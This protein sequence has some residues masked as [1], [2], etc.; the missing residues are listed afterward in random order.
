MSR[1]Q[2]GSRLGFI[3]ASA[4]ATVGL[5]SI[6]KFP[7][8]TAMNGGGAF[9][10]IFILI[11]FTLGLALLMAEIAIGRAAGCG[12]VSAFR[13][14]GGR[15]W[16]LVGYTGVL[17]G[18]LVLSFYCVVGGWTFGYLLRAFDGRVMSDSPE[19]LAALFGQYVSSPVEPIVTHAL[20]VGLTALV[21]MAGI[22]K[23]IERA[24]KLL[25]PALFVLML[26]LIVRALTLPGAAEGVSQFLAP[27]FSKVTPSMLVDA[28]GLA[29]FS[30]SVGAGCMLAYGSYLGPGVRLANA[31]LWIVGLTTLTSILA[32][33]MIFPA[34]AAFGLD[35]AAGPGLT[36]MTMPVVFNHLPFGQWFAV[37]FFALL[38]F[39]ALTSAV[40]LLEIIVVLPVDDWGVDRK[41]ASL[42]G[43]ALVFLAGIPASL[44]FG[45]LGDVT[46]FGR[47]VFELMDYTASNIL[48]PVGGIGTALFA[49]WK[50]WPLMRGQLALPAGVAVAMQAMC[51]VVAP[52]LIGL[53]L[54]WNL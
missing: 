29:F 16:P 10:I 28:L 2:W 26:L 34:I 7:Y 32:G 54:V 9:I 1:S 17:C 41:R 4:G 13:K 43:A 37:A 6:W 12:A 50:V 11:A 42:A 31:S 49:G 33:L 35:A 45:L 5:G 20:F 44:S 21:V 53:I 39:A 46:L 14:L 47:N 40:S 8:V 30:L 23:G 25:M 36:Y 24:G 15:G 27:D 22:Q 38:L 19:A 3:L 18:F 48:L 51:R 52:L